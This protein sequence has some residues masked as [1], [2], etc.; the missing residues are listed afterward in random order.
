[1]P[2]RNVQKSDIAETYYHAYARGTSKQPIFLDTSDFKYFIG[3][4]ERYLSL[5]PKI[6]KSHL[7]YPHF[8]GKVELLAYCLMN[9]HFHLLLYQKVEGSMSLFMKSVMSS[10]CMYFNLKY[11]KSGS[12]Y[13]STYKASLIN[14]D[15]YLSHI[16]RYI[17]LNPRYWQRYKYSSLKYYL[18]L[19]S[20]EWLDMAKVKEL[21]SGPDE[22]MDFLKD[23]EGQMEIL[24]ELKH[25]LAH[26]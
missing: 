9:N 16:S 23:Y 5:Q 1:M 19:E 10:Y 14:S 18:S 12:I 13:E 25:E 17:H 11:K 4:F 15:S 3:L 8:H 24:H 22:Y 21:F 26:L 6:G 20:V 2:R 7:G